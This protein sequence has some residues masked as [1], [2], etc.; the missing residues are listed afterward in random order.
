MAVQ[1]E[2]LAIRLDSDVDSDYS[3]EVTA[4]INSVSV[5]LFRSYLGPAEVARRT[6]RGGSSEVEAVV[7]TIVAELGLDL[8]MNIAA[9]MLL[10]AWREV[11]KA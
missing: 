3:P 5:K 4:N 10:M 7:S 2:G 6:F 11:L 9:G 1:H 8:S